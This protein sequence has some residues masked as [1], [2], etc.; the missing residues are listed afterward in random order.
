MSFASSCS[1]SLSSPF[2]VFRSRLNSLFFKVT[3]SLQLSFGIQFWLCHCSIRIGAK[4]K[5]TDYHHILCLL[6]TVEWE[7]SNVITETVS[8]EIVFFLVCPIVVV[9]AWKSL[10]AVPSASLCNT[11]YTSNECAWWW[12][13]NRFTPTC[14]H[15]KTNFIILGIGLLLCDR[16]V[17]HSCKLPSVSSPRFVKEEEGH[18]RKLFESW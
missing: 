18:Q 5:Q 15:S 9:A 2:R 8:N 11:R 17:L 4:T 1:I 12:K 14:R 13:A 10:S 16:D 3:W 6:A 7:T